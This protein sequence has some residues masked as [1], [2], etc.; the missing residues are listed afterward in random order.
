MSHSVLQI[1]R[2]RIRTLSRSPTFP[3]DGVSLEVMAGECFGLVGES[4]AGKSLTLR[5]AIDL[6]PAGVQKHS[7]T[8]ALTGE[9]HRSSRGR[10]GEIGMIFQEPGA[11]LNPLMRVG[12]MVAE[13]LRARGI[14]GQ[15]AKREA[16]ALLEEVGIEDPERRSRSW[17]HELSGGERQR[18]AIAL[19]LASEP[20]VLLCDEPTTALDAT[21]QERILDLLAS[22]QRE[23]NLAILLVS[24][25]LALIARMAQ[26]LAV[27]YAGK[28]VE[29]GPSAALLAN[30]L[31]PYT[32]GLLSA[33]PSFRP[34]G[35]LP[36]GIPGSRPD[37][38]SYP[39]GCRFHPRCEHMR[40]DCLA[41]DGTLIDSG[42]AR[43]SACIHW[44]ELEG[45][46]A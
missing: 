24:H 18:V 36:R 17:P 29:E 26:R 31:H 40:E 27:M 6:L 39:S 8:V 30:P 5:A 37:P 20:S 34:D 3:V 19:A 43:S 45:V 28:I 22:L 7:G 42:T 33:Q 12:G 14:R 11:S 10:A 35:A 41:A 32:A 4:G 44:Q 25:D 15:P 16:I 1:E 9:E 46:S 21:V 23:R 38:H 2:L 13:G